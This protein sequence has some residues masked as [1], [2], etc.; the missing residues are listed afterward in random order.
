MGQIFEIWVTEITPLID[1]GVVDFLPSLVFQPITLPIIAKFG[2]N[3]GNALGITAADG[4]LL[5][6]DTDFQWN[7]PADDARV[8]G[9]QKSIMDQSIA[10]AQKEGL[11]N[12][13]F[14]QNYAAPGQN[15]FAGYGPTNQQ[16]LIQI[17]KKYDPQGVFQ[18]LQP[19]YFKV[20]NTSPSTY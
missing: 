10:L 11:Y 2:T 18:T 16:R 5:V 17:S 7:D 13:Y 15:V 6:M 4:P 8:L 20:T 9:A 14:Y 19:G 3:G 1:A 12:R